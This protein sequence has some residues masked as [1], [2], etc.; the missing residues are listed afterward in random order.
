M[1]ECNSLAAGKMAVSELP[2]RI[3]TMTPPTSPRRDIGATTRGLEMPTG[4]LSYDI[5]GNRFYADADK[6]V[7]DT[8]R[9]ADVH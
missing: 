8:S 9:Y 3:E 4:R 7:D 5:G 1:D 6:S 2:G